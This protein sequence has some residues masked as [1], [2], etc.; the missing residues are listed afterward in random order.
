MAP[1]DQENLLQYLH[2][3]YDADEEKEY[4]D[5]AKR[6]SYG[7]LTWVT[8]NEKYLALW[9]EGTK[10]GSAFAMCQ[11][12]DCYYNGIGV[13]LKD[14]DKAF[15][16]YQQAAKLGFAYAV[17]MLGQCYEKGRGTKANTQRAGDCYRYGY[18]A[19][20][21]RY[22]AEALNA[23]YTTN[24]W[25]KNKYSPDI[26][27]NTAGVMS[28]TNLAELKTTAGKY[29]HADLESV[30]LQGAANAIRRTLEKVVD[31]FI[32][33]YECSH[34]KDD[35]YAKINRLGAK[36]YFTK[37]ITDKAHRVRL[38]GNRGS[39]NDTGAPITTDELQE[40]ARNIWAIVE[41]YEK[42]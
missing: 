29:L 10:R 36:G 42:Y 24:K 37:E 5:H 38:L 27:G 34:L 15:S 3:C 26:F 32:E 22:F 20:K 23:L 6:Y 40:A 31:A 1:D 39:H 11:L 19:S 17:Y 30:D 18:D 9:E 33:C 14:Y 8:W 25:E 12:A 16:L 28:K 2:Q 7:N 13:D 41:Y 4:F 35:L 21:E